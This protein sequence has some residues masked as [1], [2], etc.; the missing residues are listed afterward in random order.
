MIPKVLA[1]LCSAL[2]PLLGLVDPAPFSVFHTISNVDVGL[3]GR[4]RRR[5]RRI[6]NNYLIIHIL[7]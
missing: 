5:R 7:L 4:G 6:Q 2:H 1:A 3:L